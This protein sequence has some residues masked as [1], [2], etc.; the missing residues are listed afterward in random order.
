[1]EDNKTTDATE[2]QTAGP[3]ASPADELSLLA[4]ECE[5][6][7]AER[8]E[9]QDRWLR[10]RAEFENFRKR[11]QREQ[12]EIVERA[13]MDTVASLLPILDDFE[14]ALKAPGADPEYARGVELIYQRLVETLRKAGLEPMEAEGKTFDPHVHEAVDMTPNGDVEENTVFEEFRKGYSFRGKLLRPAMVRV[15]VKPPEA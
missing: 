1:M 5:K 4:A 12:T 10:L 2:A 7:K 15:A 14:R 3:A 11:M 13:A 8:D 9:L 6:L